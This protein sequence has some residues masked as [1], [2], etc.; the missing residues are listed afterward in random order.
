MCK[1]SCSISQLSDIPLNIEAQFHK[2]EL[3]STYPSGL[4]A[5][6]IET[7]K[8]QYKKPTAF[9]V[10]WSSSVVPKVHTVYV[11]ASEFPVLYCG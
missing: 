8:Q 9:F 2:F 3:F 11:L 6:C 4:F 7:I 10:A 5:V 1:T